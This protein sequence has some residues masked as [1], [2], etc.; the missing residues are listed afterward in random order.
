MK[1]PVHNESGGNDEGDPLQEQM[2]KD[3]AT[4]DMILEA[5]KA[6]QGLS[7]VEAPNLNWQPYQLM[8]KVYRAENLQPLNDDPKNQEFPFAFV[9]VRSQGITQN[10]IAKCGQGNP[11][12]NYKIMIPVYSP[13]F[14]EKIKVTLYHKD[15][16]YFDGSEYIL[17]NIPEFPSGGDVMNIQTLHSKEGSMDPIWFNL[18]GVRPKD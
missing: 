15:Q 13:T 1:Q 4:P 3:G 17:A 10:T 14:N 9:S 8:I 12:W 6:K 2:I 7:I 18:Y 11:A 16:S 5:Q